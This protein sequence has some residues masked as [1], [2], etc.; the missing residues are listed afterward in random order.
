M[1]I[2]NGFV[3]NSST[4]SF[5]IYGVESDRSFDED[6]KHWEEMRELGIESYMEPDSDIHY[7]GISFTKI[8]DDETGKQFKDRVEK[9]LKEYFGKEINGLEFG[10]QEAAWRDG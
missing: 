5:C 9:T 2:R 7:A 8:K 3:S 4:T 10:I 6:D 1:K